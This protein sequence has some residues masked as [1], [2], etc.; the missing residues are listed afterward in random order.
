M[1]RANAPLLIRSLLD[2]GAYPHAVD[3]VELLETH[4]SWVLLTGRYAYKVKKPLDLG[5]LDFSTPAKRRLYCEEEIRLNRRLAPQLYLDVVPIGERGGRPFMEAEGTPLEYAVKMREFPQEAQLD[6]LL[7]AGGVGPKDMDEVATR[8]ARFHGSIPVARADE[9]YGDL[10]H[11]TAPALENFEAIAPHLERASDRI[12]LQRLRSWSEE[13][14]R[15]LQG[16]LEGRK[17]DGFIRECHGDLHLSNLARLADGITAFDALE[18]N[19]EL[20]WGDVMSE[21]AFLAMDLESRGRTDLAFR[22]LNAY[23]EFTGDYPGLATLQFYLVYRTMVR[24]KV[25]AIRMDQPEL[26]AAERDACYQR[27]RNHVALAE[28]FVDASRPLLAIM[29]GLSGSGKSWISRRVASLLPAFRIRSDIERKRDAGLEPLEASGSGVGEGLYS[30]AATRRTYDRLAKLAWTA[31]HSGYS[32]LVDAA[33]LHRSQRA[34]FRQ[35]A[36][37]LDA[38]F[39]IVECRAEGQTLRRRISER[40]ADASEAGIDVLGYQEQHMEPLNEEESRWVITLDTSSEFD[41]EDTTTRLSDLLRRL[42]PE[43]RSSPTD[44]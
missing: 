19:D 7:A 21:V 34:I 2:P 33:F 15:D 26:E 32:V 1:T 18:F 14:V 5:F 8:V 37:D 30:T 36:R 17:R 27:Y 11:V 44:G 38:A 39:A 3:R 12:P 42:T 10:S 28:R 29:F 35:L 4:I 16:V 13:Q 24:S 40:T 22:F 6:R 20:R 23:L 31:L 41:A 9:V 43:R 25:A